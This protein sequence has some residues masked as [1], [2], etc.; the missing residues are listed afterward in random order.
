LVLNC[1]VTVVDNL[2]LT[3][4]SATGEVIYTTS[5]SVPKPQVSIISNKGLSNAK[6]TVAA[7]LSGF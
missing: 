5:L 1:S 2:P 6:A 4:K 7:V 3:I